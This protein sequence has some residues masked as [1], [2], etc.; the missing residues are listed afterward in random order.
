MTFE[1]KYKLT[2]LR[3]K[4]NKT[5]NFLIKQN[6]EV[7]Q[8]LFSEVKILEELKQRFKALYDKNFE[9]FRILNAIVRLPRMC[10]QFY[11]TMKRKEQEQVFEQRKKEAVC[12][13]GQ[14]VTETNSNEFFS[15]FIDNLDQTIHD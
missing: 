5:K 10:D 6:K 15:Q 3:E 7:V 13:M 11:K 8:P 4:L 9:N 1:H 12:L 2:K 14:Y